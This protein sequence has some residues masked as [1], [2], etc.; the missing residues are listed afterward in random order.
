MLL[1]L[2]FAVPALLLAAAAPQTPNNNGLSLS[3]L[4]PVKPGLWE[5]AMTTGDGSVQKMRT[6][7]SGDKA[8]AQAAL[9]KI[10]PG[11]TFTNKT[12]MGTSFSM[13]MSCKLQNV[14]S[15]G[16][17]QVSMPDAEH[18]HSVMTMTMTV[19]GKTMPMNMT[20][21]SRFV[22]SDCGGLAT[23]STQPAH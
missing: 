8:K 11:C 7:I 5:D 20:T 12:H 4:P 2:F 10:P 21:D 13:D 6:C 17:F 23:G 14:T 9:A 1:K 19:Q 22:S 3:D 18:V 16:H 15:S